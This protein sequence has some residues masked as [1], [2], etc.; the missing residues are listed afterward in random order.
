[1]SSPT[2]TI[3]TGTTL[4]SSATA[5]C[6]SIAPG[7]DGY[8]PPEACGNLLYYVPSFGAALLFAVLFSLTMIAH[9]VQMIVYKKVYSNLHINLTTLF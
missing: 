5:T 3:A 7:K 4:T 6:V 1:M 9:L 8:L 2:T